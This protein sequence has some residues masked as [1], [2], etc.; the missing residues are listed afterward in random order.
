MPK[1]RYQA[2]DPEGKPVSGELEAAGRDEAMARLAADGLVAKKEKV[3][4]ELRI[5][6]R[7]SILP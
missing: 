4:G 1:F 2:T 7:R 6:G 3:S 5:E